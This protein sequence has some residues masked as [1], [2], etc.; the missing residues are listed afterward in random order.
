MAR[1]GNRRQR[2]RTKLSSQAT[3]CSFRA[4]VMLPHTSRRYFSAEG[5]RRTWCEHRFRA[6]TPTDIP[7]RPRSYIPEPD[8][9]S[10]SSRASGE[11]SVPLQPL[12]RLFS[13]CSV[14]STVSRAVCVRSVIK[15]SHV[16]GA[17]D[18]SGGFSPLYL[19]KRVAKEDSSSSPS[20]LSSFVNLGT[21]LHRHTGH[22]K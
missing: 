18:M 22:D 13:Y 10:Y 2:F 1:G 14:S 3:P 19:G 12:R 16:R 9:T 4:E 6:A 8:S 11:H 7:R 15:T 5:T 17:D 21:D 20:G